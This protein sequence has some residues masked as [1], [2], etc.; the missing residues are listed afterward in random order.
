MGFHALQIGS[1]ALIAANYGL[2]VT[3][4]N[5]S[6]SGTTGY[7]R[8]VVLQSGAANGAKYGTGLLLGAGV[9]VNAVTRVYDLQAEKQLRQAT[10]S[11][12][13]Y[14]GLDKCYSKIQSFFGE[15]GVD[16][17]GLSDNLNSFWS[18]MNNL[19][20]HVETLSVRSTTVEDA[21]TLTTRLNDLSTQLR[22]YR[23]SM[24]AEVEST[25]AQINNLI[26][27]VANLNNAIVTSENGGY[28][29]SGANDLRD[30]RGELLRQ[31]SELINIDVT[32][33]TNGSCIVSV[34]GRTLVYYD[35]LY[36][37]SVK[38]EKNGDLLT[39]VPVFSRDSATVKASGG[40]LAS[41][42][43]IRDN[44][45][46]GYIE[47]LDQLAGAFTWE[48][49]R[50]YSQGRGDDSF[51]SLTSLNSPI[52]P[53]VTLDQ[54]E[55]KANIPEG[56]FRIENGNLQVIVHNRNTGQ[57][58]TVNVE[59]DL[60]GRLGPD[61]E[62]DMILWDPSNPAASNSFINRLQKALDSAIPGAFGVS[63]D[64]EYRVTIES[65]SGDYGFCF[66]EDTSGILAA[67]GL[68]VLFTGHDASTIGVNQQVIDDPSSM[69]VSTSFASGDNQ[70]VLN[71]I[72][73]SETRIDR[74]NSMTVNEY[75]LNT[76]GRLASES[77]RIGTMYGVK[78]DLL[79]QMSNLRESIS[80]VNE[81]EETV[82]L[83]TY[84]RAYQS[85]AKYISIV[86]T[87]YETLINM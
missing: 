44:I 37:L 26:G 39:A 61:G 21:L 20:A 53:S 82:K 47:E 1:S 2:Q 67:L 71:L 46:A 75:Y 49:N 23:Q 11:E 22:E 36:D 68:N 72:S 33:E 28:S 59:I 5:L 69:A 42:I 30:E 65:K 18:S 55:Y 8:Q 29:K 31:L 64:N 45:I 79:T 17:T 83:I 9:S 6:N 27:M 4:Q 84:Q 86:D 40:K 15:L 14:S 56:T 3:G 41:Q 66:G 63:I 70:G 74:L 16:S 25:V 19:S 52:D 12:T 43:E 48:F 81:D 24:N 78:S 7:S 80:G 38:Y 73:F 32:D 35:Q 85:A 54:L 34:S 62:P 58:T 76:A 57:E 87:I 77:S 51:D 10:S 50:I 13:Y 60:D